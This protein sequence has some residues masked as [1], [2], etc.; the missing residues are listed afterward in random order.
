MLFYNRESR[1][2]LPQRES[3]GR[4]RFGLFSHRPNFQWNRSWVL[5]YNL[6]VKLSNKWKVIERIKMKEY[7]H[8]IGAIILAAAMI[9][10][11]IIIAGAIDG[12]G[13]S[14]CSS[15]FQLGDALR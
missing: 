8:L 7:Q 12:A 5:W 3:P 15:L 1:I 11:A 9:A 4:K 6:N 2:G 13:A 14:I 10:A